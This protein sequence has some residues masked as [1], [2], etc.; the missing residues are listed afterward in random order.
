MNTTH[1]PIAGPLKWHGG[2]HYLARRF[3]AQMPPHRHSVEPFAG[4]LAVLRTRDHEGVSEV[5]NDLDG[6]LTNFWRVLQD[7]NDLLSRGAG[8]RGG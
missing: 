2:K 8:F 7:D 1:S 5:A 6:R 3:V 4:G